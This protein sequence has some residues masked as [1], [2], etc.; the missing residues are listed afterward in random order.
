M[1]F[2]QGEEVVIV[3]CASR[4]NE[5]YYYGGHIRDVKLNSFG[6]IEEVKASDKLLVGLDDGRTWYVHP[7][8]IDYLNGLAKLKSTLPGIQDIPRH[9][10][11]EIAEQSPIFLIDDMIYSVGE[12]ISKKHSDGTDHFNEKRGIGYSRKELVEVGDFNSLDA[13][14]LDRSQPDLERIGEAYAS[15]AEKELRGLKGL[16][17]DLDLPQLIFKQVFPYLMEDGYQDKVSELLGGEK[18]K[19]APA[20]PK[21]DVKVSRKLEQIADE[22]G[23]EVNKLIEQIR[24]EDTSLQRSKKDSELDAL[25]GYKAPRSYEGSSL[26]GKAL[27]GANVAIIDGA[28]YNLV[29]GADGSEKQVQIGDQTFSVTEA[30]RDPSEIEHRFL[31]ELGKKIRIDALEEHLSRDKIIDLL[32][33]QDVELLAMAGKTEYSG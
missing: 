30:K 8:E 4:H 26:L 10:V 14:A 6:K 5:A 11:F 15:D 20:N 21:K 17:K 22:T 2:K 28:V 23:I 13:L 31:T 32:R 24:K 19:K 18:R 33:T 16:D 3:K 27:D 25:L 9:P 7:S 29:A 1:T 12:K